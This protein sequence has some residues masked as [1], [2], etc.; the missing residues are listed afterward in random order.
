MPRQHRGAHRID[1][2]P[3]HCISSLKSSSS[4]PVTGINMTRAFAAQTFSVVRGRVEEK[5]AVPGAAEVRQTSH[6]VTVREGRESPSWTEVIARRR[7][8][9]MPS[10]SFVLTIMRAIIFFRRNAGRSFRQH[11]GRLL[12]LTNVFNA[13]NESPFDQRKSRSTAQSMASQWS[14]CRKFKPRAV[15]GMMQNTTNNVRRYADS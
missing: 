9:I 14:N 3:A 15:P 6:A 13:R 10:A 7:A 11:A 8:K 1:T 5:D 4:L 12:R 2:T